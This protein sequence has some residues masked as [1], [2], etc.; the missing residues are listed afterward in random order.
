MKILTS[1]SGLVAT[2]NNRSREDYEDFVLTPCHK[3]YVM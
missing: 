1:I 2:N 3:I